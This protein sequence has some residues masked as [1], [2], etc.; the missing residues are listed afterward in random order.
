MANRYW[1]GGTATWD[2]TAGTK[3]STTSGGAGGA[4]VPTAV[5]DV[6][7]NGASGSNTITISGSRACRMLD[8]TG[9]TGTLNF[10]SSVLTLGNNDFTA[11]MYFPSSGTFNFGTSEIIMNDFVTVTSDNPLTYYKITVPT[12]KGITLFPSVTIDTLSLSPFSNF[13]ETAGETVTILT[14]LNATGTSGNEIFIASDAPGTSFSF[15]K[16]SGTVSCDYLDLTDCHATG[17]AGFYAGTH[18]TNNG[19]N[20]GWNFTAPSS[21]A[22]F[23]SHAALSATGRAGK[24]GVATFSPHAALTATGRAATRS[25]ATLSPHAALSG[26]GRSSSVSIATLSPHTAFAGVGRVLAKGVA[27]I[28]P[29]AALSFTGRKTVSTVGTFSAHSSLSAV[30]LPL[31][32]GAATI[33]AHASLSAVGR[34]AARGA[35]SIAAHGTLSPI[36][37]AMA[38]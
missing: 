3:W 9:F 24:N 10:G 34:S 15:S 38:L 20:T 33:T 30:G 35:T 19:N 16:S 8:C 27:T 29:Q 23:S 2:G 18:S 6:F 7:F 11:I 28:S 5:D 12:L 21:V 37:G 1:V 17:G 26:V 31:I 14:A 25:A 36:A 32:S 22:T 4:A 13:V